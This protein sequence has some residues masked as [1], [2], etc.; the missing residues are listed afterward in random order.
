MRC[1][2]LQGYKLW[3]LR[4]IGDTWQLFSEKFVALWDQNWGSGDAYKEEVYN[5]RELQS[6][7]Q[8][9]YMSELFQDSL[10]YAAAKMIRRIVGIAHVEDLESI[11]DVEKKVACERRALNFA[12]H[13][14]KGRSKYSEIRQVCNA[15]QG[16]R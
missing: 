1:V 2:A 14:L 11:S 7:A 15:L 6:L 10:G 16:S 8:R 13:L 3:L 4:T 5:T 12:K 9:A